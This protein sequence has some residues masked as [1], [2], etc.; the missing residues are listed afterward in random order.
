LDN[1]GKRGSGSC[2]Q[3]IIFI[4]RPA[5]VR[6]LG[7]PALRKWRG[8]KALLTMAR[9]A[10][11]CWMN[12]TA[13]PCSGTRPS[14]RGIHKLWAALQQRIRRFC[15]QDALGL[16]SP[17]PRTA[18]PSSANAWL[19]QRNAHVVCVGLRVANLRRTPGASTTPASQASGRT[20]RGRRSPAGRQGPNGQRGC[21]RAN[22]TSGW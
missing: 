4:F 8:V 7:T 16:P 19:V 6:T 9:I 14:C 21:K 15:P 22:L 11:S 10:A 17:G 13:P 20:E 12:A 2:W 1:Q 5:Q 3:R 18:R